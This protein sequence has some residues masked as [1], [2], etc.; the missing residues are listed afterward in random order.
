MWISKEA[1]VRNLKGKTDWF[2]IG[3]GIRQSYIL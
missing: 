1:T 2:R 3:K